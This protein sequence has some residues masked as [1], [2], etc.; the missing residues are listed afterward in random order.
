MYNQQ[1]NPE[2]FAH[3]QEGVRLGFIRKNP[4]LMSPEEKFQQAQQSASEL[5]S[6]M[7]DLFYAKPDGR[8]F[9]NKK[10]MQR[11]KNAPEMDIPPEIQKLSPRERLAFA[12]EASRRMKGY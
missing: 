6:T 10:F 11:M 8:I 9:A 7:G 12:V 2:A 4:L 1:Y 5:N 3:Y